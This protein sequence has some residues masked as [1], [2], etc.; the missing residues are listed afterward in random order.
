MKRVLCV[1]AFDETV[2]V[3]NHF[4][5]EAR[6]LGDTLVAVIVNDPLR[7]RSL[8]ERERLVLES[9]LADEVYAIPGTLDESWMRIASLRPDVIAFSERNNVAENDRIQMYFARRGINVDYKVI[10]S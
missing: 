4:L 5:R 2:S 3:D 8:A 9:G 6:T 1:G 10:R 7:R